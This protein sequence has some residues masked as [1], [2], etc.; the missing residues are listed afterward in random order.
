MRSY[1]KSELRR[2]EILEAA[3]EQF[4]IHG[5]QATHMDHI[6]SAVSIARVTLYDYYKSKE[7]ILYAL[8]DEVVEE[9]RTKPL[10]GSVRSQLETLAEESILRLMNNFTLYKILFQQMPTLANK[11]ARKISEWQGRSMSMVHQAILT[12][13]EEGVFHTRLKTEDIAFAYRAM[14]GQRLADLLITKVQ[15]DPHQEAKRLID[16]L[17]MGIGNK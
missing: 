17:W 10:S 13:V 14:V 11:T 3:M 2:A 16:L 5:Y 1:K 6:A 8:I 12:G 7:D 15:V 9:P 4:S